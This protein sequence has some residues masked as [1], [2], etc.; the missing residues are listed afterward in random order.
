M[1]LLLFIENLVDEDEPLGGT[2]YTIH[3]FG[4][5]KGTKRFFFFNIAFLF[6][7]LEPAVHTPFFHNEIHTYTKKKKEE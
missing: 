3:F 4:G 1:L 6:L 2:L 5:G 7:F